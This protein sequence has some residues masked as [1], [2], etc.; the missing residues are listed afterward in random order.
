MGIQ[1]GLELFDLCYECDFSFTR[2]RRSELHTL[3]EVVLRQ[4]HEPL[5]RELGWLQQ[6]AYAAALIE[7]RHKGRVAH[8][9]A[10]RR[11]ERA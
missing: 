1:L 5:R 3:R 10:A 7:Q 11:A 6:A 2:S 4:T 9:R 8:V